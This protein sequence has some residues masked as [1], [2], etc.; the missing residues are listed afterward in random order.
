[1]SVQLLSDELLRQEQ[2]LRQSVLPIGA[3]HGSL[4]I[5]RARFRSDALVGVVEFESACRD[6]FVLDLALA[7]TDWAWEPSA[8]QRG[9]PAGRYKLTKVRALLDG[10]QRNRILS[11]TEREALPHELRF[12]AMREAIR[13]LIRHDL[14]RSGR[15]GSRPYRDYRHYMARLE[16]LSDDRAEEMVGRALRL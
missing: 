9:G 1:S 2:R 11:M 5:S 14:S 15:D 16:A 7:L 13:C 10:Y 6:R 4:S 3:I 8:R 12:V